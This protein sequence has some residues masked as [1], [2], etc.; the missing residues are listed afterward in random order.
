MRRIALIGLLTLLA[1]AYGQEEKP[2]SAVVLTPENFDQVVNGGKHVLVKFYAP[3]CGHCKR[4]APIWEELADAAAADPRL[5]GR[6]VVA[7]VD[8][9]AHRS[10]GDR[11]GIKGFPTIK[12]FGRGKP[13]AAPADYSGGRTLEAFS[14][15]LTEKVQ[16]DAHARVELL[17]TFASKFLGSADQAG[18]LAQT[19]E[20]VL[21][22]TGEAQ[23]NGALYV[24]YM[25]KAMEKGAAWVDTELAR[26]EKLTS[27]ASASGAK[28][29]EIGKKLSVLSAFSEEK[30]SSE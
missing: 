16:S 14:T 8:A 24:R 17:D 22:L 12:F 30:L 4:L 13:T 28:L 26:L 20:A 1:G 18:L 27:G 7:K 25:K 19:E 9:D 23:A 5:R 6:V 29:T 21:T 15:F 11:Y 3:W 10:L 2:G